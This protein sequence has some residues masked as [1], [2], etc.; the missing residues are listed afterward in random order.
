MAAHTTESNWNKAD[1]SMEKWLALKTS[2]RSVS[3]AWSNQFE[4]P[5]RPS[6]PVRLQGQPTGNL[7]S[8]RDREKHTKS[9]CTGKKSAAAEK[10]KQTLEA[11][12]LWDIQRMGLGGKMREL[13]AGVRASATGTPTKLIRMR[14]MR[15]Q[16]LGES[17]Q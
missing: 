5:S 6:F 14:L 12:P 1:T 11:S 7:N 2:S 17:R 13:P 10:K 8:V 16:K 15:E 4:L 3:F 9:A